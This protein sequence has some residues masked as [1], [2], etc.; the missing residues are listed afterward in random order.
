MAELQGVQHLTQ[1]DDSSALILTGKFTGASYAP[2]APAGPL[3]LQTIAL[4]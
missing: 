3:N 1:L 4:P 2:G